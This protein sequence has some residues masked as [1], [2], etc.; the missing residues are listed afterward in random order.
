MM[1]YTKVSLK[2]YMYVMKLLD[3]QMDTILFTT[4]WSKNMIWLVFLS[5]L[6]PP[7]LTSVWIEGALSTCSHLT[8]STQTVFF[9]QLHAWSLKHRRLIAAWIKERLITKQIS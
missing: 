3:F 1:E 7:C 8:Q 4:N 2:N 6:C 9:Y 5:G